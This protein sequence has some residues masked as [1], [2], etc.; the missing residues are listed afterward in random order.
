MLTPPPEVLSDLVGE[1]IDPAAALQRMAAAPMPVIAPAPDVVVELPAG[2]ID[3]HGELWTTARVREL[4]GYDEE[5]LATV[6]PLKNVARFVSELL[7]AG[8]A[9]LGG[10][11]PTLET[12]RS[13]L[14]GD[15]DALVL[16]IR[17]ATY[18]SIVEAT[19]DCPV[20]GEKN[21]QV[22]ID[23]DTDIPVVKLE[24]PR[25][26]VFNV[27]L[28]NGGH[29]RV[30]LVNGV[31]QEKFSENIAKKTSAEL[32]TILLTRSVSEIRGVPTNGQEDP[33]RAL[34]MADRAAISQFLG[35]HQPGPRLN[36]GVNV[37]CPNPMC[38]EEIPVVLGLTDLFQFKF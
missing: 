4:T 15:R 27:P 14:L 3:E 20:C 8:V 31:I 34:S 17:K 11:P 26:R 30:E 35:D 22:S 7:F 36:A 28:R 2:W 29:A 13:L 32:D 19:M 12:I 10:A 37:P 38:R 6:D 23:L 5:H 24:N 33:V 21:F 9:E 16:G 25:E 18:G 1:D